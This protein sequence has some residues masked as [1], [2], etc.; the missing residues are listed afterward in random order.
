MG[1][2]RGPIT[3]AAILTIAQSLLLGGCAAR[4]PYPTAT[5]LRAEEVPGE[6]GDDANW[7]LY[8]KNRYFYP[9]RDL[10]DFRG[11]HHEA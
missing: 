10:F 3:A 7:L 9:V 8:L 11:S 2:T 1:H 5:W 6:F 4:P